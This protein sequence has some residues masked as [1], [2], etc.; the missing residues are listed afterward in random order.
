MDQFRDALIR[1]LSS[2]IGRLIRY[3]FGMGSGIFFAH[4]V[5]G[6]GLSM[7]DCMEIGGGIASLL[8]AIGSSWFVSVTKKKAANQAVAEAAVTG[9]AVP[10]KVVPDREPIEVTPPKP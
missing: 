10:V 4:S 3:L 8:V 6:E 5:D 2:Q 7:N 9:I 1:L